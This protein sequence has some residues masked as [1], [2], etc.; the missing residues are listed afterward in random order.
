MAKAENASKPADPRPLVFGEILMCGQHL[1]SEGHRSVG[2]TL[3]DPTTNLERAEVFMSLKDCEFKL[4]RR[5]H[6]TIRE[7]PDNE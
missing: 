6:V 1:L 7:E 5:Y 2:V 3:F 4:G